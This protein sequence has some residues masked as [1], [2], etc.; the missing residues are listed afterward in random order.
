MVRMVEE[1][2][3]TK[4]MILLTL[5]N[6]KSF[7]KYQGRTIA[8]IESAN[9]GSLGVHMTAWRKI[10]QLTK[11]GYI[12]KGVMDGKSDTYY[13]LDKGIQIFTEGEEK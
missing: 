10:R 7:D 11:T 13:L 5:Y 2:D 12:T 9:E 1:L 4:W 6:A 3:R 8:E